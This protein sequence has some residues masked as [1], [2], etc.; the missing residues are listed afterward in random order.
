MR[1]GGRSFAG[2]GLE[3]GAA[4]IEAKVSDKSPGKC[5]QTS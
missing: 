1:L 2:F 4:R 3:P 5:I